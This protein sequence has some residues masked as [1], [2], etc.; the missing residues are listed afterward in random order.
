MKKIAAVTLTI[1]LV[2]IL[3]FGV[4]EMPQFGN[5]DNPTNNEVYES[6]IKDTPRDTGALNSV[7]SIVLEYR[8]YDTLGESLVLFLGVL[9]VI[10]LLDQSSKDKVN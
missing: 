3:L 7:T 4:A 8:A 2:S 9:T 6:Y 5:P 1:I 10:I